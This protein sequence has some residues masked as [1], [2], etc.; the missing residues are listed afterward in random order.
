MAISLDRPKRKKISSFGIIYMG[1]EEHNVSVKNISINGLLVQ[2]N[3]DRKYI[4]IKYIFNQLL[5]STIIDIYLPE[6]R[7]AGEVQIVRADME[8]NHILLA[9][10]FRNMA[11]EIEEIL[12]RRKA[13]R[14]N[15]SYAG[16]ILLK[17]LHIE[18][19]TVNIS[20]EGLMIQILE[21]VVVEEGIATNFQCKQFELEGKVEVIWVD[22][23]SKE[24]TLI[25]LKYIH[26]EKNT[27]KLPRF[28]T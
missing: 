19:T 14:K 11:F 9:L 13:Y 10:E 4:D 6:M 12:N 18:F 23:G 25:G 1:E 16:K 15:M 5:V 22:A 27:L 2:I 21:P 20:L 7:L 3:S 28:A 8:G 17:G 24:E 26:L